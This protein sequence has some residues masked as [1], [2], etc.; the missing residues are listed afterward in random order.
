MN[1]FE[2]HSAEE[3]TDLGR[4]LAQ[5]L[6]P[7]GIVLLRGD[8]GAGKTTMVKGIAEG[9]QARLGIPTHKCAW[10]MSLAPCIREVTR[11][12][13]A[14]PTSLFVALLSQEIHQGAAGH[15]DVPP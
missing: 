8:L 14:P 11:A 2:T 1:V 7:G 9:F 6:K 15:L 12:T 5:H 3:T 4:R 10:L 13:V